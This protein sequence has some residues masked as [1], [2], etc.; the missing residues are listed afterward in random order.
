MGPSRF[1]FRDLTEEEMRKLKRGL[2]NL[3]MIKG[4]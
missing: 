4:D 3:G 1:P 2:V